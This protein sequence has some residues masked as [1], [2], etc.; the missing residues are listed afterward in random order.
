MTIRF[1]LRMAIAAGSNQ[2][3]V[4][5]LSSSSCNPSISA[6]GR[7]T[8]P[9][10]PLSQNCVRT[11]SGGN[12]FLKPL[13]LDQLPTPASNITSR[14]RASRP[15]AAFRRDML[16]LDRQPHLPISRPRPSLPVFPLEITGPVNTNEGRIQGVEA[17][18]TSFFDWLLD[19]EPGL[20][21][22]VRKRT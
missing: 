10:S 6:W 19:A 11:G 4:R 9:A 8:L 7:R 1:T 22:S 12:P 17:Q 14:G 3:P 20:A 2:D 5:G 21:A 15:L 13:R 18:F 16:R